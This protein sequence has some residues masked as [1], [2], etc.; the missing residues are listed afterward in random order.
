MYVENYTVKFVGLCKKIIFY[1]SFLLTERKRKK[2]GRG[3]ERHKKKEERE[4]F[5][6][7][8]RQ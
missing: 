5:E 2:K 6:T 3:R 1:V 7:G 4:R 8:K